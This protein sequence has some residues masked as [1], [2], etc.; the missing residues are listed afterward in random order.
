M[1]VENEKV[2]C[3]CRHCKRIPQKDYVE[4]RCEIDDRYLGYTEVMTG[5]CRHWAKADDIME[6]FKKWA[7]E[8]QDDD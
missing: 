8:V 1:S 7:K 4:C 5:W 6:W 2:C 3:N